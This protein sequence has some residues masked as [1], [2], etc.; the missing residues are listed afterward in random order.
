[1][2]IY[3]HTSAM[4][5]YPWPPL[6]FFKQMATTKFAVMFKDVLST[7]FDKCM[8]L[9]GYVIYP[10]QQTTYSLLRRLHFKTHMVANCSRNK[11]WKQHNISKTCAATHVN[12]A[13]LHELTNSHHDF[14]GKF[15]YYKGP[16]LPVLWC[17]CW[18]GIIVVVVSLSLL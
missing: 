18:Q 17:I 12:A 1:M 4:N 13:W 14:K 3:W 8:T 9:L 10:N 11:V 15:I 16:N 7:V 6:I 2:L 5:I